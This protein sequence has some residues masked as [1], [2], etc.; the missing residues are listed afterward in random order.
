MCDHIIQDLLIKF[1]QNVIDLAVSNVKADGLPFAAI[2][3][4]HDEEM[5]GKRVNQAAKHLDCTA[6]AETKA[7]REAS[8]N[9]KTFL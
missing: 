4:N 6:H 7:I 1:G 8:R 9:E 3:I 5:I 2:I